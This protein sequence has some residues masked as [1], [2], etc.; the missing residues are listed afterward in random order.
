M[1]AYKLAERI[2]MERRNRALIVIGGREDKQGD[3]VILRE[4][5]RRVGAGKLVICTAATDHPEESFNEYNRVFRNLGVKHIHKLH[6]DEREDGKKESNIKV[7]DDATAVFFT[8]GDQLKITSQLGDTPIYQRIHDLYQDGGTIIGTSSGASVM[9]ETMLISGSG[10]ESHRIADL[11]M[12]PGFGLISGLVIDQHF[13]ERGRMGRLIGTVAQNPANLGIGIDEDTALILEQERYFH[14]LGS[15]AVYVLDGSGVTDS[16]IGEQ[17]NGR[18]LS[19]YNIKMHVLAEGDR[20]DC[21][22]RR[23]KQVVRSET[24]ELMHV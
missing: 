19:I 7:L 6:I 1:K 9:C 5:A 14:V 8:G 20:F 24:A 3:R 15:G 23:P 22:E 11:R 13:A 2:E 12:A 10:D 18:V 21:R 16:N 17:T 4:V